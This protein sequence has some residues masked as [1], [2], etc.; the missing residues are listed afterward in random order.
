MNTIA[1]ITFRG[2]LGRR[3]ALL[4]FILPAVLLLLSIGLRVTGNAD[5]DTAAALLTQFGL[6]ALLPLL[7]LLAG[8][9]VI[10][11]EI[12]DGQIMYLMTKPIARPIIS[13]TKYLVAVALVVGFGVVPIF[14]SGLIMNGLT[15]G[16][17]SGF[18]LGALV[19]GIAYCALFVA[20]AVMSRFAVTIGLIYAL[21]W[22]NLIGRY[23]SGARTLS[24]R[25]W[26]ISVTD[27]GTNATSV[28]SEV[29]G[30]TAV[31]LLIVL[32][33]LGVAVA[34]WKLRTLSIT[35]SD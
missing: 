24:V 15:A 7:A 22:E 23:A 21:V 30:S 1:Y 35:G 5:L 18:A 19:G 3:R 12:D 25:Q 34:G 20:L 11:P 17:A 4:L 2:M 10:G 9:G 13:T 31:P 14:V 8:T 6:G 27:L 32:T 28:T 29:H 33:V 16:L 26:A